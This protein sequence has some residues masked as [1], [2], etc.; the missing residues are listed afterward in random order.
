MNFNLVLPNLIRAGD[1]GGPETMPP[2][3]H[4]SPTFLRSKKK[5]G[6]QRQKER[7]SRQKL[8]KGCHQGQNVIALAIL[9]RLDFE[10]F[11]CRPTLVA[12]KTFQ[13]SMAPPL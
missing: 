12:N 5:K 8:L 2:L 3:P 11:S 7:V 13:C 10:N 9:E 1:T 6:R 4:S